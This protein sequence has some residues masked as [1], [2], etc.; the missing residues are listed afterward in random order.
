MYHSCATDMARSA[1]ERKMAEEVCYKNAEES[2][3][4]KKGGRLLEAVRDLCQ[5]FKGLNRSS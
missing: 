2:V 5:H 4:V 3:R 1:V